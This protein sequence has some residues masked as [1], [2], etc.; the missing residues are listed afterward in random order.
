MHWVVSAKE[1]FKSGLIIMKYRA[2]VMD[3]FDHIHGI[4]SFIHSPRYFEMGEE[5]E[6]QLGEVIFERTPWMLMLSHLDRTKGDVWTRT[7]FLELFGLKFETFMTVFLPFM[8]AYE[9][10]YGFEILIPLPLKALVVLHWACHEGE[11]VSRKIWRRYSGIRHDQCKF[12]HN[13]RYEQCLTKYM[14]K[15]AGTINE[16]QCYV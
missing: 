1:L 3:R 12:L 6:L 8:A 9:G 2:V 15:Y 16:L 5:P 13:V 11:A 7:F 4:A 14:E 10:E